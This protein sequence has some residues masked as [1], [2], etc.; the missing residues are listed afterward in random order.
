MGESEID[1]I[2]FETQDPDSIHKYV[3]CF[4]VYQARETIVKSMYKTTTRCHNNFVFSQDERI[5]ICVKK[6]YIYE[7]K[8]LRHSR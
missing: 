5:E 6:Q 2:Y 8:L 1:M 3:Y 4:F 7:D